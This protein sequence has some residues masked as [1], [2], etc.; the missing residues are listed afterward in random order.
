MIALALIALVSFLFLKN[1][2][3]ICLP[4]L[5]SN[6]RVIGACR[7]ITATKMLE[8]VSLLARKRRHVGVNALCSTLPAELP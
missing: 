5:L 4:L 7:N 6:D 3:D 2:N 1:K 8:A